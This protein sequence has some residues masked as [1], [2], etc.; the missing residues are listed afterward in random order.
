M[1]ATSIKIHT[2]LRKTFYAYILVHDRAA[3]YENQFTQKRPI[4]F[5]LINLC[6]VC[7]IVA[8]SKPKTFLQIAQ[9]SSQNKTPHISLFEYMCAYYSHM[10]DH[11]VIVGTYLYRYAYIKH[12]KIHKSRRFQSTILKICLVSQHSRISH[13]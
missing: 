3:L 9:A 2:L 1:G 6:L 7:R 12:Q 8:S 10:Y 4:N 11:T 5:W 13:K